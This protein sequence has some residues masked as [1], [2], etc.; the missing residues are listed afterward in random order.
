MELNFDTIMDGSLPDKGLLDIY[1]YP[2]IYQSNSF[3]RFLKSNPYFYSNPGRQS[4]IIILS[5]REQIGRLLISMDD[6]GLQASWQ[7]GPIVRKDYQQVYGEIFHKM[8]IFLKKVGIKK[9]HSGTTQIFYDSAKEIL[10]P[11]DSLSFEG[12]TV[13]VDLRQDSSSIFKSFDR[14]VIKNIQKCLKVGVSVK[15]INSPNNSEFNIYTDLLTKFRNRLGF[16]L[17]P[18]YPNE[19]TMKLFNSE[20]YSMNIGLGI[21]NHKILCAMGYVSFGNIV[22]EIAAVRADEYENVNLPINDLMKITAIEK[23][24]NEGMDYY[25]ITGGRKNPSDTK[26]QSINRFKRKFSNE[27][28]SYGY[29]WEKPLKKSLWNIF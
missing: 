2:N 23:F 17:P 11:K 29:I 21:F 1:K 13:V 5:G 25:D 26:E 28:R 14:S 27:L 6:S 12:E 9:I 4:H 20:G 18:F 19:T 3:Y 15:F 7:S 24:K 22:T 10:Y 16:P 8:I